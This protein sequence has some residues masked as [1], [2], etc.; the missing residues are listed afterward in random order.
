MLLRDYKLIKDFSMSLEDR[1][2]SI[3]CY[4]WIL[5]HIAPCSLKNK[6]L[7]KN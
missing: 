6:K 1:K 3:V 7:K 2:N 4:L 5:G